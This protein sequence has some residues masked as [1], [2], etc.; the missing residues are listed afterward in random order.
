MAR[1]GFIGLGMMG[2]GMAAS[3]MRGGHQLTVVAHRNRAPVDDLV[4][5]GAR[6]AGSRAALAE[7]QE[8][9]CL[10]VTGTPQVEQ[11][12]T[13]IEPVLKPG[14]VVIDMGTSI[15]ESTI[16]IGQR[17]RNR[18]I[19]MVDAPVGG[20]P[21]HAEA[22]QLASMVGATD[23]DFARVK[24]WLDCT[25]KIVEHM[26]PPGAGARAKLI[27]NFI[28]IS[29]SVLVIEGY[30]MAREQ[31]IAWQKLFDVNMGGA[32]RSGTLERMIPPAINGDY[33]AYKFSLANSA[34]DLAYY[35]E[36]LRAAGADTRVAQ[37]ML[38]Y[39]A[40]AAAA[41]GGDTIQSELLRPR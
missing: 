21:Q 35:V 25:S 10:C 2:H 30:R 16:A 6:E 12:M 34:K 20:G 5:R 39:F 31:G 32:A 36:A 9:V 23:E 17:L 7:G 4:S 11:V 29:Q 14:Q 38:D 8:A 15:P 22:G 1:I 33:S 41:H 27:N 37:A 24:P 3:L 26:G 28:A 19:A 18:G 13:E 40:E